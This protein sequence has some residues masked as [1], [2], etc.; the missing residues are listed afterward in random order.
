MSK[1]N[2]Q[3]SLAALVLA[4]EDRGASVKVIYLPD[5]A[6]GS[7]QGIDDYLVAGGTIKEMFMLARE[8]DPA[9]VGRIRMSW[10]EQQRTAVEELRAAWWG[11]DWNRFVGAGEKPHWARGHSGRDVEDAMLRLTARR[12][13]L[14]PE[15]LQLT[16]T[17]VREIADEAA[18]SK[19]STM[20]AIRH[21]E[22]E[23]RL[24]I[25]QPEGGR[26]ARSYTLL[27][28]RADCYHKGSNHT[29]TEGKA[30]GKLQR[31]VPCGKRLRPPTYRGSGGR[32]RPRGRARCCSGVCPA[33]HG[34]RSESTASGSR[35]SGPTA[36]RWWTPWRFPRESCR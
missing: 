35:D 32:L 7:K 36:A 18:K 22:A 16:H 6:D 30:T 21:L 12:G 4:L 27:G 26:K 28:G 3:D 8:F 34:A 11:A 14:T 33:R 13:K 23:G 19:P 17:G 25:H 1:A 15:G 31:C 20:K 2:V 24:L 5:A 29:T 9:D 10:N